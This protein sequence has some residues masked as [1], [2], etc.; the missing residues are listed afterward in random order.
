[1][2]GSNVPRRN[3]R[4][5]SLRYQIYYFCQIEIF[6][7]LRRRP[8]SRSAAAAALHRFDGAMPTG[9]NPTPQSFVDAVNDDS[10]R[11]FALPFNC[12]SRRRLMSFYGV[13]PDLC[14][15][16]WRK[17]DAHKSIIGAQYKYLM[18]ALYFMK[19]Y[20]NEE[21]NSNFAGGVDEKTFRKW[22]HIFVEAISF[23]ESSV[24]SIVL[25]ILLL[26]SFE[27]LPPTHASHIF[28]LML[29]K[30]TLGC[31]DHR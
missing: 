22:S 15:I 6:L 11:T 4:H 10:N 1:V 21:S 18:W 5:R 9:D 31:T 14:C 3:H 30:D 23:L 7:S 24:V 8:S 29:F 17:L 27:N 13:S 28:Q 19:V 26:L 12:V 20:G 2:A 16:I 25:T